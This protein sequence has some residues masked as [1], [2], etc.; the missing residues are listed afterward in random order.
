[1]VPLLGSSCHLESLLVGEVGGTDACPQAEIVPYTIGEAQGN[2]V[3][4][5]SVT[6][7]V[8]VLVDLFGSPPGFPSAHLHPRQ[9]TWWESQGVLVS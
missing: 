4:D 1:M 9:M 2:T 7:R 8:I 6:Y 5:E 3:H